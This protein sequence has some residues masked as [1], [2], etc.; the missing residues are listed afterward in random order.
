[1]EATD[2]QHCYHMYR[3]R[4]DPEGA[5]LAVSVDQAHE[6][7]KQVFW[8]EGLPLVEFQNQ[9]LPGHHLLQ[10]KVGYGRGCPWTCHGRSEEAYRI[11]A[12]PGALEAIRCSLVVGY[13]A[14]AVLAN[15]EV[16]DAYIA[17]FRKLQKN[18]RVFER[19]ASDLPSTPPWLA[20]PRMF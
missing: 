9:P 3:F 13:P 19:F 20:Q 8:A 2:R 4:F 14:Q 7:L 17:A 5:G 15:S 18:M 10:R 12:Y 16:V 6:A 1:M 11:E